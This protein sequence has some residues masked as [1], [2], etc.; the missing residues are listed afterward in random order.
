[1]PWQREEERAAHDEALDLLDFVGI[2]RRAD[3]Y[4]RNLSYG[5]QRRLEV[6]RALALKPSCCCSTSRPPA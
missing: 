2:G 1:M 5:D 6:A 3:E 4:A